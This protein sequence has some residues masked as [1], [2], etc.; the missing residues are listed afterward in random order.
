MLPPAEG[1]RHRFNL[2][3]SISLS[4]SAPHGLNVCC[5][6]ALFQQ[7]NYCRWLV[8]TSSLQT[9][10]ARNYLWQT[11]RQLPLSQLAASIRA[12]RMS[13]SCEART[14]VATHHYIPRSPVSSAHTPR[15]VNI[16]DC[17]GSAI[18]SG[19]CIHRSKTGAQGLG[20]PEK[21]SAL[22]NGSHRNE[23]QGAY[24]SHS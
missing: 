20:F 17:S 23:R 7:S 1:K 16:T 19:S 21:P 11:A 13:G 24:V 2:C 9:S 10:G 3:I 22:P 15:I 8:R 18:F 14:C 5:A 4:L 6:P 12:A